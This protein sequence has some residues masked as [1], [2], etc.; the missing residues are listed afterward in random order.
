MKKNKKAPKKG[1]TLKRLK[2]EADSYFALEKYDDALKTCEKIIAL[3]SKNPFGYLGVIKAKTHNYKRYLEDDAVKD[4]K[5]YFDGAVNVATKNEKI[6]IKSQYDEYLDDCREVENLKRLKKQIVGKELLKGINNDAI[7]FINQNI[8]TAS[9]YGANGRKLTNGY[10]FIRG[11][12]FLGCLVFNLINRNYLLVLTIPFGLFGLIVVYSFLDVNFF[13]KGK[14]RSERKRFN[15]IISKAHEK[16][17]EIKKEIQKLDDNIAFLNEQKSGVILKI[18]ESFMV[19]IKDLMDGNERETAVSLLSSLLNNNV[20]AFSLALDE[21]TSL[22]ADTLIKNI[23]TNFKSGDDE[24]SKFINERVTEKKKKQNEVIYMKKVSLFNIIMVIISV[25]VSVLTAVVVATNFYDLN[26]QSFIMAVV[27]GVVSI[28]I[29]NINTGK[30]AS[31]KDTVSDNLISCIFNATLVY[32]LVYAAITS[33]LKLTYGL[34]QMPI[35][36]SLIFVGPVG[37][38]SLI[39][40]KH[41]QK[42]LRQ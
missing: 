10:D 19:Q 39:K 41:L 38:V 37:V 7:A 28:I 30:H 31:V 24:L 36:F 34:I 12:F 35:I 23:K 29:Y 42:K 3:Y 17:L 14:I 32:D 33:E 26:F 16:V 8:T 13:S 2:E 6:K 21:E 25:V 22:D 4:L 5:S 15:Q 1:K 27:T 11:L 9:A 18:P 40:Y 20:S